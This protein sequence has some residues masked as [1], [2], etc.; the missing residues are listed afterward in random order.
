MDARGELARFLEIGL[1]G[2]APDEIRIRRIRAAAR[3]RLREARL[4]G[5]ESLA[6]P[7]ACAVDEGAADAFLCRQTNSFL[8]FRA[9]ALNR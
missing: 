7:A 3:D 5:E 8:V 6:G 2:L 9:I 1:G 4:D